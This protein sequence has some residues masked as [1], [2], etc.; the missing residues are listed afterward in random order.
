MHSVKIMSVLTGKWQFERSFNHSGSATGTAIFSPR[1]DFLFYRE[2]GVLHLHQHFNFYRE[3]IF[4]VN[5]DSIAVWFVNNYK[6]GK[7]F[8]NLKISSY[9]GI[10]CEMRGAHQCMNDHYVATYK[11]FSEDSFEMRY[12][13]AGP[14]KDYFIDTKYRAVEQVAY[15]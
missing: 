12:V 11:I 15:E 9:D 10:T 3:Y 7:F 13:I 4:S 8:Y 1:E 5:K 2:T 6:K 14:K